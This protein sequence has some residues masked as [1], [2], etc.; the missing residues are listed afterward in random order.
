MYFLNNE[1]SV[2]QGYNRMPPAAGDLSYKTTA[3]AAV[4]YAAAI[5]TT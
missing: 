2:S 4:E 1:H 3:A 5:Q